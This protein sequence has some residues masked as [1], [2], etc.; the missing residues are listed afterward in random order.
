[1]NL[2]S[3]LIR[4][5]LNIGGLKSIYSL[6]LSSLLLV[7]I[8]ICAWLTDKYSSAEKIYRVGVIGTILC[9]IPLYFVMTSQVIELV[10]FALLTMMVFATMVLC[11]WAY[12]M[13][14][15]ANDQATELGIGYNVS[16]T[17]IGGATPLVVSYLVGIHLTYVGGFVALCCLTLLVSNWLLKPQAA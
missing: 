17:I 9:S 8:G 2:S 14:E 13:A 16:S 12:M 7:F 5:Y 10:F 3:S 15:K 1:M 6:V 4:E 11:N